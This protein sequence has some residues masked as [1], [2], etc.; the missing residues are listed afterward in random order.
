MLFE[1]G[2]NEGI[3]KKFTSHRRIL[4]ELCH[5]MTKKVRKVSFEI[6]P[7]SWLLRPVDIM[8]KHTHVTSKENDNLVTYKVSISDHFCPSKNRFY[9]CFHTYNQRLGLSKGKPCKHEMREIGGMGS[10]CWWMSLDAYWQGKLLAS[11]VRC[12]TF[13]L[14]NASLL[15][16]LGERRN[17]GVGMG[18]KN[19]KTFVMVKL[20]VRE[21]I[22]RRWLHTLI[23]QVWVNQRCDLFFIAASLFLNSVIPISKVGI[24]KDGEEL[25]PTWFDCDHFVMIFKMWV[26]LRAS[27]KCLWIKSVLVIKHESQIQ[28]DRPST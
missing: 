3:K 16:K 23:T 2:P 1:S 24:Q 27:I 13:G 11:L 25:P 4:C 21:T 14:V 7:K 18:E 12:D 17:G 8:S 22:N 20:S 6:Q 28:I 19:C 5:L 10:S 26:S 15:N 9:N